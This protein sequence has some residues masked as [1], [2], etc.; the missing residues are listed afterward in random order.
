[1]LFSALNQR[2]LVH[3]EGTEGHRVKAEHVKVHLKFLDIADG[4]E[5]ISHG[6][7]YELS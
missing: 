1:M 2:N 3:I 5:M 7:G 6:I 4:A